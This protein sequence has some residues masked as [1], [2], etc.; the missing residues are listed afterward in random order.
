[1]SNR[2]AD[3]LVKQNLLS[4]DQLGKIDKEMTKDKT[5]CFTECIEKHTNLT[6]DILIDVL[7]KSFNVPSVKLEEHEIPVD[8]LELIP[9]PLAKKHGVIPIE[10]A[11][12]TLILAMADPSNL[13]AIDDISFTTG[14]QIQSVVALEADIQKAI[15]SAYKLVDTSGSEDFD[16]SSMSLQDTHGDDDEEVSIGAPAIKMAN[17]ILAEAVKRGVSDIHVEPYEKIFR[18]RY[19]Q[20]GVLEEFMKVP[21]ELRK[22]LVARLKIMSEMRIDEKRVPQDGRIRIKFKKGKDIDFR[23]NSMP[24][25]YGEKICLRILDQSNLQVDMKQLGFDKKTLDRFLSIIHMPYGMVLVTGPTGSGK[26]TTLYSALADLNKPTENISTAEDPVEFNF[27]GVNQVNVDA[28]I[29]YDFKD[30]LKAFL[31]Q[32]PD[33]IMIGEIRDFETGEIAIKAALTGHLVLSTLHTNSAPETITRLL[34][35]GIEPF[36]VVSALNG[37]VA[38]RLGRKLCTKCLTDDTEVPKDALIEMGIPPKF[39]EQIKPKKGA[40]CETC[41]NT[42]YKGRIAFYEVLIMNE[43]LK[44]AV[45]EN[46][47]ALELKAIAIRTGMKTLRMDALSKFAEGRIDYKEVIRNTMSDKKE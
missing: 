42:G 22:G 38:Q 15:E 17:Y 35:M 24:T 37:I 13:A 5:I 9:K 41:N 45:V 7:S 1:M 12:N 25:L 46:K 27:M 8:I 32:D 28:A 26:T 20:D 16:D 29:G 47:S 43:E 39:I 19:R 4:Q 21:P 11:A 23:V 40:G 14:C 31:R 33:I 34:N 10:K 44:K 3:I 2:I 18:V 36:N 6:S 30:A